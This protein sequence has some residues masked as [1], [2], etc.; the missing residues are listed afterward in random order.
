MDGSG[1]SLRSCRYTLILGTW[2]F[3]GDEADKR[4]WWHPGSAFRA[5]LEATFGVLPAHPVPFVWS[6]DIDGSFRWP[7]EKKRFRDWQAA[8]AAL[9]Y[10]LDDVIEP[11]LVLAHSHGGQVAL[12][13]AAYGT[14]IDRLVTL[15]T[16]VRRDMRATIAKARPNIGRWT[17]VAVR[18][19]RMQRLGMIFDGSFSLRRSFDEADRNVLIEDKRVGHS[20]SLND[21]RHFHLWADLGLL[22]G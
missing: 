1:V 11:R 5:Y 9:G 20:G 16:P 12:M 15:G 8:G 17:H 2:G 19:D 13:A 18:G 6:S 4:Q 7:W 14:R 3:D 22:E 21:P 10:Y